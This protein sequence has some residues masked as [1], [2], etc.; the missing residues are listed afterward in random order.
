M[1]RPLAPVFAMAG[2]SKHRLGS[3]EPADLAGLVTA[4]S[5][6]RALTAAA[7][8]MP[9]A[10]GEDRLLVAGLYAWLVLALFTLSFIEGLVSAGQGEGVSCD[11]RYWPAQR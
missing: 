10:A 6:L 1:A 5:T 7:R 9:P 4:N 11:A 2:H 8:T 3:A